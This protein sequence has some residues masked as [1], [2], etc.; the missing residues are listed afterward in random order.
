MRSPTSRPSGH[1]TCAICGARTARRQV[2]G[3]GVHKTPPPTLNNS[4]MHVPTTK[5]DRPHA[6]AG[7]GQ[8]LPAHLLAPGMVPVWFVWVGRGWGWGGV[9]LMLAQYLRPHSSPLVGMPWW[10]C[11]LWGGP[12]PHREHIDLLPGGCLC[13]VIVGS[14]HVYPVCTTGYT[15]GKNVLLWTTA[16][17][18]KMAL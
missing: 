15:P 14:I 11:H 18:K 7:A 2:C 16:V 10:A 3:E 5:E 13:R 9:V 4:H 17:A 6:G 8:R 1:A 12:Q